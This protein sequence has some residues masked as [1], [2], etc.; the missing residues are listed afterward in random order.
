MEKIT[1]GHLRIAIAVFI[2]GM[3]FQLGLQRI[4]QPYAINGYLFQAWASESFMQT[5][6]IEDLRNAPLESLANIHIQ[7]P[8]YDALRAILVQFWPSLEIHDALKQVDLS[9]YFLWAIAYSL[10]G[11]IVFLWLEGMT[12]VKFALASALLF[13]LHPGWIY[14]ATFLDTTLPSALLILWMFYLLWKIRMGDMQITPLVVILLLLFFVR[15]LFQI[16]FIPVIAA[17]LFLLKMPWRKLA[18][19]LAIVSMVFGLY[20][21]KQKTQF[22]LMSTSS[23][24]GINLTSS[25]SITDYDHPY[26]IDFDEEATRG[27]PGV[28]SRTE[29]ITGTINYNN[30]EYLYYN[31]RL[32]NKFVQF[33]KKFP[34]RKLAM[35]YL[36]N[37]QIYFTPSSRYTTP[38]MIVDHLPWRNVYERIFSSP[39]FPVLLVLAGLI[40]LIKIF[41]QKTFAAATAMLLPAFYVFILCVLFEKGENNR[42]KFFLEPVYYVFV[43]SQLFSLYTWIRAGKIIPAS[44]SQILIEDRVHNK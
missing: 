40:A 7:P 24:T 30:Y 37:L 36:E 31:K 9:I 25:V 8:G 35:N 29:K 22:N 11:M 39:V 6:S 20:I 19:F 44:S 14:Y 17:T 10:G 13:F 27:L 28:L 18:L 32:T 26:A 3:V 23:F 12:N 33:I 2:T 42:Y 4:M 1:K 41:K 34:V 5:V 43:F 15:S 16:H 21:I 38:H